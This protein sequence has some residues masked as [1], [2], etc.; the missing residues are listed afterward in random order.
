MTQERPHL[1]VICGLPGAGSRTMTR[2]ELIG[3]CDAF[4]PPSDSELDLY[5]VAEIH[6]GSVN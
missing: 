4:E 2:A 5:D 6:R 1:I 3:C